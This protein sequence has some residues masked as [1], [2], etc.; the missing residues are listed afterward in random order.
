MS[1]YIV[2]RSDDAVH[3][4][5][6]GGLFSNDGTMF[7]MT[8]KVHILAHWPGAITVL[9]SRAWGLGL[10]PDLCS[11]PSLDHFLDHAEASLEKYASHVAPL[12]E[13]DGASMEFELIVTGYS[14]RAQALVCYIIGNHKK[15]GIGQ[16]WKLRLVTEDIFNP[17]PQSE[18]IESLRPIDGFVLPRDGALVMTAQRL[19]PLPPSEGALPCAVVDGF[20]Q[21]TIVT[22]DQVTSRIEHRWHDEVG[23]RIDIS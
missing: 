5:T 3:V 2:C 1:A 15:G 16:P 13:R 22:R 20:I 17:P 23:K 19:T 12:A 4:F 9:G 7:A 18:A 10:Y 11:C 6:D 21:H 14:V 8:Q